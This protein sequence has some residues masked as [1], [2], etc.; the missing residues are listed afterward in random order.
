LRKCWKCGKVG[1]YK[2]DC[3]SKKVDKAKGSDDASSTEAKTSTKKGDVYLASTGTHADGGVW[4]IN[5]SVS[6]HMTPHREWFYENEK[7]DGGDVFLG[8]DSTAK[9]KGR[10]RVKSLLKDGRI[11]TLPRVLHIPNLARSLIFVSKLDDAGVDTLLGKGTCKM[12]QREMLLMRGVRC[13]TLY[14]LLGS[15]YT[16]GCNSSIVLE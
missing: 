6:F 4:L 12:V 10:E 14:K 15:T 9:I 2:K 11:R 8:D 13:G 1:H 5:S 7:Y 16:D 3:T